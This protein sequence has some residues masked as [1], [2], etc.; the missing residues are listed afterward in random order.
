MCMMKN[1]LFIILSFVTKIF[2]QPCGIVVC[3]AYVTIIKAWVNK[4][5]VQ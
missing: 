3:P 4:T 2:F 1:L 5:I